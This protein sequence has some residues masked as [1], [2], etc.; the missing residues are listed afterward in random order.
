M[1]SN[2]ESLSGAEFRFLSFFLAILRG[3]V[4]FERPEKP[5]GNAGD[6]IHRGEKGV[7][8]GL[9]GLGETA[10][11]SYELER[12]GPNLV[13]GDGRIEV[14]ERFDIAAHDDFNVANSTRL[15]DGVGVVFLVVAHVLDHFGVGEKFELH[16][17]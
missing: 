1:L 13:V 10:D 8:V 5:G 12:G 6:F 11:L 9:R 4:G 2:S 14:E 17:E 16:R 15:S 7:L 3:G